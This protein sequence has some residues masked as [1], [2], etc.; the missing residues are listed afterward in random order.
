MDSNTCKS[1]QQVLDLLSQDAKRLYDFSFVIAS[2]LNDNMVGCQHV[3]LALF[4]LNDLSSCPIKDWL[5]Q[6]MGLTKELIPYHVFAELKNLIP[7]TNF[8]YEE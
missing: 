8:V 3:L 2:Q 7:E 6:K 4:S 5:E 1:D